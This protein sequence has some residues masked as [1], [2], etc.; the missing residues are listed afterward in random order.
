MRALEPPPAAE[1]PRPAEQVRWQGAF[2]CA[3]RQ[4]TVGLVARPGRD[5]RLE[6]LEQDGRALAGVGGVNAGL[7]PLTHLRRFEVRCAETF[8]LLVI[9]GSVVRPGE[10]LRNLTVET[11]IEA[12]RLQTSEARPTPSY[13][14]DGP[15]AR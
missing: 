7:A 13:G 15:D 11:V 4:F 3:R 8:D 12:G 2:D 14:A 6:R 1:H 10:P 9:E 5:V